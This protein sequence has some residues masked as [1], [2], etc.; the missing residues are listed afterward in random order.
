LKHCFI[1]Q[2]FDKGIFDRRFSEIIEPVVVESGYLPYRVDRDESADVIV[3]TIEKMISTSEMCIAE[4]TTNNPNV[5]Y[6][7]GYAFAKGKKVIMLCSDE[8]GDE[9][10]PFDVRHRNILTYATKVPSDFDLLKK[11]LKTRLC[12]SVTDAPAK[13]LT[14]LELFLLKLIYNNL[15]TP[16]EVVPREKITFREGEDVPAAL[17]RLVDDGF[18]EYIYSVNNSDIQSNYYRVTPKATPLIL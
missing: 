1:M 4:I 12:G 16:N 15:N 3:E 17:K 10:F 5:W 7:L 11:R 18:L 2:P 8:R 13:P 9:Q 6:E 14:E